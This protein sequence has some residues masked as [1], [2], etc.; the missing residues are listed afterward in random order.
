[1]AMKPGTRL[2]KLVAEVFGDYTDRTDWHKDRIYHH[3]QLNKQ[4]G[5]LVPAPVS[6]DISAAWQVIEKLAEE[7]TKSNNPISV[8]VIYDCGAYEC[9]IETFNGD[10]NSPIFSGSYNTAPEAICKAA[11]LIKEAE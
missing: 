5:W 6:T 10:W 3:F 11:L 9:K 1:M 4:S 2:D 8:E 7:W